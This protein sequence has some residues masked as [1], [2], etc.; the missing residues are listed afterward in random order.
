M[1]GIEKMS[2]VSLF[3]FD[4]YVCQALKLQVNMLQEDLRKREARWSNT[5]NRLRQQVDTLTSENTSLKDQVRMLEKLRLS[6]WKSVENEREKEKAQSAVSNS[7][8]SAGSKFTDFKVSE[9]CRI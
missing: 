4:G 2:V 6:A 5:Q 3:N 7:K 9:T 1:F 8:S